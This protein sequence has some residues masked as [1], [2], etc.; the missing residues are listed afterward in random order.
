MFQGLV[1]QVVY[2]FFVHCQAEEMQIYQKD[3]TIYSLKRR[4]TWNVPLR[5]PQG[6][7]VYV[8]MWLHSFLI[9]RKLIYYIYIY[10]ILS[11]TLSPWVFTTITFLMDFLGQICLYLQPMNEVVC[12]P[13]GKKT[14][15]AHIQFPRSGPF[16][17]GLNVTNQMGVTMVNS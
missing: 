15:I 13:M 17:T 2:I 6:V 10:Y 8:L 9:V 11:E 5:P 4:W 16:H 1:G 14:C 3:L 7:Q 12:C